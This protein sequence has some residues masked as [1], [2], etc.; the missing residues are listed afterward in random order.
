MCHI[1]RVFLEDGWGI[2]LECYLFHKPFP[3]LISLLIA[4]HHSMLHFAK[5]YCLQMCAQLAFLVFNHRSRFLWSRLWCLKWFYNQSVVTLPFSF[6]C[7]VIPKGP[8]TFGVFSHSIFTSHF[9]V[10]HS[11]AAFLC[12]FHLMVL[13]T[14]YITF[15]MLGYLLQFP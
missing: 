4:A 1:P 9:A 10:G 14:T 13:A 12:V 8:W 11:L 2:H 6:G 7:Y 3:I 5:W 15:Y